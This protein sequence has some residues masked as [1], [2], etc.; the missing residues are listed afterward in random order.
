MQYYK[1]NKDY[2]W[3]VSIA[4]ELYKVSNGDMEIKVLD[5]CKMTAVLQYICVSWDSNFVFLHY[6]LLKNSTQTLFPTTTVQDNIPTF[7]TIQL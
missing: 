7:T 4:A 1:V 5:Q 2:S 6:S 3:K